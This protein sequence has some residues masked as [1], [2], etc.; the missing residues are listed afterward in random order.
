[1]HGSGRQFELS[2][3][4][5]LLTSFHLLLIFLTFETSFNFCNF[6]K[7]FERGQGEF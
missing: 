4:L 5:F 1:M 2:S 3:M 6:F 7:S